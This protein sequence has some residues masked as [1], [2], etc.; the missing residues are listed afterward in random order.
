[1]VYFILLVIINEVYYIFQFF[2]DYSFASGR[3]INYLT[4]I[5]ART[6]LFN[7]CFYEWRTDFI[8]CLFNFLKYLNKTEANQ[9]ERFRAEAVLS[10]IEEL[11]S[12]GLLD[13]R[14]ILSFTINFNPN[15]TDFSAVRYAA[16]FPRVLEMADKFGN[17]VVAIRGHSDQEWIGIN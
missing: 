3:C 5:W 15:Q 11:S 1:M 8:C 13:D 2:L 9:G 6:S 4:C 16:E 17:A 14:T 7:S 10:E 12:G